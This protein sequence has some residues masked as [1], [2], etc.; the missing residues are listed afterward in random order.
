MI[1][2]CAV[3]HHCA[4][5]IREGE[6]LHH[7]FQKPKPTVHILVGRPFG[8]VSPLYATGWSKHQYHSVGL[9]AI[10]IETLGVRIVI[11]G[12]RNAAAITKDPAEI[13]E[14]TRLDECKAVTG[15]GHRS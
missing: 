13:W 7:R 11:G 8:K 12:Y 14:L 3:F 9:L 1:K 10:Y 4:E 5:N 6:M 15:L 2:S